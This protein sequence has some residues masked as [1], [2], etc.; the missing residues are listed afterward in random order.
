MDESTKWLLDRTLVSETI[1]RY[2][3]SLDHRDWE[4]LRRTL[5]DTVRLDFEQL[6]GDPPADIPIEAFIGFC[7][8]ALSGFEATQHISPNHLIE[9]DGDRATCH[10]YMYAW[11]T[12]PT[13]SHLTDTYVLRGF[14]IAGLQRGAE[15][16]RIDD[17]HMTVWDEAGNKGVYEIAAERYRTSAAA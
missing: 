15:G 12:V 14:Y 9:V 2:F 16:W 17:L 6:F 10:A 3:T 8:D 11:H 13:A 7:R 4:G 1:T 5:A